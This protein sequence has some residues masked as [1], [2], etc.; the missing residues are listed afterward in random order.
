MDTLNQIAQDILSIVKARRVDDYNVS[1]AQVKRWINYYRAQYIKNELNKTR[2]I[3]ED[4]VQDLGCVDLEQVDDADC[5][6]E[7]KV[8]RT[9]KLVPSPVITNLGLAITRVGP[10]KRTSRAFA[11]KP[12]D[13]ITW[14]GYGRFANKQVFAYYLNGYIYLKI[15][16]T[17]TLAKALKVIN[18]RGV[19]ENP[20]DVKGFTGCE[21]GICYGESTAYP[22][23]KGMTNAIINSVLQE[24]FGIVEQAVLDK[25][26]DEGDTKEI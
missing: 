26:N 10:V 20:E 1:A 6:A 22:I 15:A 25:V 2:A 12:Y 24:R 14:S 21:D 13:A 17:H 23:K 3:D 9:C 8:L 11:F 7:C 4:Y 16:S 5:G 18:I 19:F